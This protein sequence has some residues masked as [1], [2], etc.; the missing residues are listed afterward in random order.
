MGLLETWGLGSVG[1]CNDRQWRALALL[2]FRDRPGRLPFARLGRTAIIVSCA[3][4]A[5]SHDGSKLMATLVVGAA[6]AALA[7]YLASVA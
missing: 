6:G 1:T 5:P 4:T 3:R 7:L 2:G